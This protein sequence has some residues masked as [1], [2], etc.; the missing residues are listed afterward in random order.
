MLGID[1]FGMDFLAFT[2]EGKR[3]A[4]VSF[5]NS[6]GLGEGVKEAIV[7]MNKAARM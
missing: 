2:P 4:R 5:P 1:R 7:G 3:M 6:I